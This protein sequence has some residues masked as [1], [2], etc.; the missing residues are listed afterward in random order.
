MSANATQRE[1]RPVTPGDPVPQ[2][3]GQPAPPPPNPPPGDPPPPTA[4]SLD[5]DPERVVEMLLRVVFGH[6]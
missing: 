5:A 2:P 3:P 6:R 4:A 1:H